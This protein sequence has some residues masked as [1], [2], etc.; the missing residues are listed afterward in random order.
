MKK[1]LTTV[2]LAQTILLAPLLAALQVGSEVPDTE[3]PATDGSMVRLSD[4]KGSWV[5][6]YFY[7]K[8]DTPGCTRQSCSLRD[9]YTDLQDEGIVVLGASLDSVKDQQAFREGQ[10]LPFPLLADEDKKLA[11]AFDV[12]GMGG[13]FAQRKTFI[14]DPAGRIAYVYDRVKISEHGDEVL[15]KV[16]ELKQ[17]QP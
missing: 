12:L 11:T 14:I 17:A 13:L 7:P 10:R 2:A 4:Y 16:K 6:L 5:V 9:Q 1:I 8:A 15:A 3:V